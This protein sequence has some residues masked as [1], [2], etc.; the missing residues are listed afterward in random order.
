MQARAVDEPE[1]IIGP[2]AASIAG[3]PVGTLRR[4]AKRGLIS[5][6]RMP[7]SHP[8]YSRTEMAAMAERAVQKGSVLAMA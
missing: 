8:R 3:V 1:W 4:M 5:V 7:M 2:A 6:R